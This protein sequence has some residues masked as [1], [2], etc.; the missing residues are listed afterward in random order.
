MSLYCG[1]MAWYGMVGVWLWLWILVWLWIDAFT[2]WN[3][4]LCYNVVWHDMIWLR[5]HRVALRA[6]KNWIGSHRVAMHT[7]GCER[8]QTEHPRHTHV[9]AVCSILRQVVLCSMLGCIGCHH[10]FASDVHVML[11]RAVPCLSILR[12]W[13]T[14]CLHVPNAATVSW[15]TAIQGKRW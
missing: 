13:C 4:L 8:H 1:G 3:V 6:M 14:A 11:P 7:I 15:G 5:A 10:I 2:I 9:Y 12:I